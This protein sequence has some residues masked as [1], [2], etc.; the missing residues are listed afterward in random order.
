MRSPGD[1]F[2]DA[3]CSGVGM[4]ALTDFPLPAVVLLQ[5]PT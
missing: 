2:M 5:V 1:R 4:T 3:A